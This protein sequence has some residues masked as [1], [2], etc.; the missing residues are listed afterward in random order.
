MISYLPKKSAPICEDQSVRG[1]PQ[2][3][4]GAVY[5]TDSAPGH[6]YDDPSPS[7]DPGNAGYMVAGA[8]R[9]PLGTAF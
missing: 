8:P 2:V 3:C 4:A 5:V 7:V 9:A 1:V 6:V